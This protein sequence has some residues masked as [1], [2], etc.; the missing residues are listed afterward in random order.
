MAALTS[1]LLQFDAGQRVFIGVSGGLDSIV[2]A[3]LL[4]QAHPPCILVHVHHH[5]QAAADAWP[6]FVSRFAQQ[7]QVECI[8][9]HVT[10]VPRPAESIEAFARQARYDFFASL[11]TDPTDRLCLAH[12][13]DDQVETFF[14]NLVRG[15]GLNGL[16]AMPVSRPLGNGALLR[17][18]LNFSR[19]DLQAYAQQ[20]A[21]QWIED[22]SNED[23][24]FD[25]NFLR[26]T[27][28]PQ[29]TQRWPH[30][31]TQV[32]SSI[33]HLQESRVIMDAHLA[34]C[35]A[36]LSQSVLRLSL[37]KLRQLTWEYQKHILQL[38]FKQVAG[39]RLST[40]HLERIIQ[41]FLHTQNDAMPLF[42]FHGWA[43]RRD[44]HALYL[45]KK[46]LQ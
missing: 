46:E 29:L 17:P 14:L 10:A 15:S 23:Q 9:H 22:P 36:D 16:T 41:D 19:A 31:A 45:Q 37:P 35:L 3:H 4:L 40:V 30:F 21:L 8:I 7:H 32:Q 34:E 39:L 12:H 6:D 26:E 44:R 28:L 18:L 11:L 42:E 24:R 33:A 43:L 13:Q 20:Y 2:L 25:R 5:L 38:W 27:V 1:S